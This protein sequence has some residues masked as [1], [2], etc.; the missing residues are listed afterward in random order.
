MRYSEPM[1]GRALLVCLLPLLAADVVIT[2]IKQKS[3]RYAD[4]R[5]GA[6]A[7]SMPCQLIA[8]DSCAAFDRAN[9]Q[10]YCRCLNYRY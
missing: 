7:L 1:A 5:T 9:C 6:T 8:K 4:T 10:D 2:D 3:S